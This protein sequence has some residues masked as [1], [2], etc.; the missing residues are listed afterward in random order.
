M[1]HQVPDD[2]QLMLSKLYKRDDAPK[3]VVCTTGGGA[4]VA[5]WLIGVAGA[6]TSILDIQIPYL[7]SSMVDFV[8]RESFA[9]PSGDWKCS[10]ATAVVVAE[11]ALERAKALW[12]KQHNGNLES[13]VG[14]RFLGIGCTAAIASTEPKKGSHRAHVACAS[15]KGLWKLRLNLRKGLRTRSEEDYMVS[16]LLM[17]GLLQASGEVLNEEFLNRGLLPQGSTPD[18]EVIHMRFQEKIDSLDNLLDSRQNPDRPCTHILYVP[19]SKK[20]AASSGEIADSS[21]TK[22]DENFAACENYMPSRGVVIYP[23]SFNPL[24]EGNVTQ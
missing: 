8:G 18:E 12:L 23:G 5:G 14:V 13:L 22:F 6:S 7:Q 24:H 17:N 2:I 19:N 15:E 11:R 20:K 10:E 9:S 4:A 1:N 16:R 3:I 21:Y